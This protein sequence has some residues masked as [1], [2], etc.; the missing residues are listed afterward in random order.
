MSKTSMEKG[1][2][3]A[4]IHG[5][6]RDTEEIIKH[7][8]PV[9]ASYHSPLTAVYRYNIID[10]NNPIKIGEVKINPG[11]YILGD[12]DGVVCIPKNIIDEVIE[13]AEIVKNKEDI[14]RKELSF[15]KNIRDLFEKYKVF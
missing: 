8:F 2:K 5:G 9:F 15:G 13:Q 10:F 4:I 14:V 1:A 12:I 6:I 11:D 7:D 3:G